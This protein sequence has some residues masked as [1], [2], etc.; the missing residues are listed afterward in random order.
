MVI[1]AFLDQYHSLVWDIVVAVIIS[2]C[3][4]HLSFLSSPTFEHSTYLEGSPLYEFWR[5]A[6]QEPDNLSLC[7]Q[8]AGL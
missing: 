1:M 2:A 3:S 6:S 5:K 4:G 7:L 8:K